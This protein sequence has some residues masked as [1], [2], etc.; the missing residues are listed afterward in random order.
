MS[1]EMT[2]PAVGCL[3]MVKKI[4]QTFNIDVIIIII[5]LLLGAMLASGLE[6]AVDIGLYDESAYL[7]RGIQLLHNGLAVPAKAPLYSIW[8]FVLSLIQ[9]DRIRLYYLNYKL[10][11]I[12]LPAV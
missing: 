12:V 8:Y 10:T 3:S 6:N 7:Y 1:R 2:F 5:I 9:P 11:M 4:L